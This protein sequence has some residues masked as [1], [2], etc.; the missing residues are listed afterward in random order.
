MFEFKISSTKGNSNI[1]YSK[2]RQRTIFTFILSF[3]DVILLQ[4]HPYSFISFV[5]SFSFL[6]QAIDLAL[7]VDENESRLIDLAHH[8]LYW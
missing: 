4:I 5:S 2:L 3:T 6:V 1:H 7:P 8:F